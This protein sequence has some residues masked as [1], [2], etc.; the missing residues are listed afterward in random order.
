MFYI[1]THMCLEP[2]YFHSLNW[3]S[4]WDTFS[5]QYQVSCCTNLAGWMEPHTCHR[6]LG[7]LPYSSRQ[8]DAFSRV[9]TLEA[10]RKRDLLA[11][12]RV[13]GAFSWLTIAVGRSGSPAYCGC[14]HSWSGGPW[15]SKKAILANFRSQ[16]SEH[17]SSLV[18][19]PVPTSRFL[20]WAPA[21]AF[22]AD[23]L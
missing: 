9:D 13:Y 20:P 3:P 16:A 5:K 11:S 7:V 6:S 2:L 22:L 8:T 14:C 23:G 15:L 21:L 12:R 4:Q 1:E 18:S 17:C 19:A 10:P